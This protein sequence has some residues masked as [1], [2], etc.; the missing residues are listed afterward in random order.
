VAG[1]DQIVAGF[2]YYCCWPCVCDTQDFLKVDTTN[3]TLSGEERQVHVVVIGN[4]CEHE[5]ALHKPFVQPFYGREMTT[6]ARDAPEVRCGKD[7]TLLGASLSDHG[8]PIVSL[9]FEPTLIDPQSQAV[10]TGGMGAPHPGRISTSPSGTHYNDEYEF[11]EM[12]TDRAANGYNSGMGEIFRK[13]A[14]ISKIVP[15]TRT[16]QARHVSRGLEGSDSAD[17]SRRREL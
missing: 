13:V 15:G 16:L 10:A 17:G 2:M 3:I 6:L 9:F 1:G 11:Q 12:C 14:E 7:G 5:E 8:Y 4:P